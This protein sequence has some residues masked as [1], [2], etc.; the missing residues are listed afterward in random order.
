MPG[1]KRII[2]YYFDSLRCIAEG[3]GKLEANKEIMEWKWSAT[4]QGAASVRIMEKISDNKFIGTHKITLPNGN[5]MED[6][7]EMTRK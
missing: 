5:K 3:R 7:V 1:R 6:E 4:A 2:G